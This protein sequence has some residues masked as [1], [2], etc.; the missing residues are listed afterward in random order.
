M[1]ITGYHSDYEYN[2]VTLR[3]GSGRT[4]VVGVSLRKRAALSDK[5]PAL[6]ITQNYLNS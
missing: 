5:G 6:I 4:S 2:S 3:E 1:G